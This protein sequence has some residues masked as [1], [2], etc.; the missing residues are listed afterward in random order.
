[1]RNF[2]AGTFIV[3]VIRALVHIVPDYLSKNQCIK[4]DHFY[5]TSRFMRTYFCPGL[6]C[7]FYGSSRAS[8]AQL[9]AL[10]SALQSS[11]LEHKECI[12]LGHFAPLLILELPNISYS[13]SILKTV[14]KCRNYRLP[15]NVI[16]H[17]L[18]GHN[19]PLGSNTVRHLCLRRQ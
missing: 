13:I 18:R 6:S 3:Y 17:E 14:R 19:C 4:H 15:K 7:T 5:F 16:R 8:L 12:F 9:C 2:F 10:F 11:V 1:M